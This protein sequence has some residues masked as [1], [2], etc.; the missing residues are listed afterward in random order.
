MSVIDKYNSGNIIRFKVN[1]HEWQHNKEERDL[2]ELYEKYFIDT[3]FEK[4]RFTIQNYMFQTL[5]ISKQ[6]PVIFVRSNRIPP[7]LD[8]DILAEHKPYVFNEPYKL[9][10]YNLASNDRGHMNQE[11]H[12]VFADWLFEHINTVYKENT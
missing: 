10:Q 11:G 3:E 8:S 9:K 1:S 7:L 4:E 2:F 12:H 6:I 5:L